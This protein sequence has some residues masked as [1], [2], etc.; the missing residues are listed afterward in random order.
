[1]KTRGDSIATSG[2]YRPE[3]DGLRA[4]A[5]ISVVLYHA[6]L[7]FSGGYVGVDVF[8][9]ISGY[10]ITS[11][12]L[13]EKEASGR[14]DIRAFWERRIRRIFPALAVVVIACLIAGWFLFLPLNYM[15]LGQSVVA[16]SLLASNFYFWSGAEYFAQA[17]DVK[18]LLHTWSLAVEEQF[19]LLFPF[20][21]L[22]LSK[23][24]SRNFLAC[25]ILGL[26]CL[27][28]SLSVYCSYTHRSVNFYLLPTRAWELLIGSLLAVV[29]S[30]ACKTRKLPE[31]M[32]FCG[33]FAILYAA[34]AF[35]NETR[36][37][38]V[39]ALLPC[40]GAA[41]VI[42]SNSQALTIVGRL[43]AVRSI[44]FIGLISYSLY[45]WHWPVLV[46]SQYWGLQPLS[47][48]QRV[49]LLCVSFAMAVVSWRFVEIPFRRRVIVKTLPSVFTV[50][51]VIT[52]MLL[53]TGLVVVQKQGLPSRIS[54]EVLKYAN[55][56]AVETELRHEMSLED[57]ITG[58]FIELGEGN[59]KLPIDIL[60]WGD[61][62]A[63]AV[64]PVLDVL[65]KEHSIRG[66]AATHSS[67]APLVGYESN[68]EYSLG[69]DSVA[70]SNAIVEFIR[71]MKIRKV[72]L[73]ARWRGYDEDG[74]KRGILSTLASLEQTEAKYWIMKPVPEYPWSVPKALA[75]AAQ[76]GR[77]PEAIGLR[78]VD[79]TKA[80]GSLDPIF[81]EAEGLGFG[82]L[83]PIDV[84]YDS[85][86]GHCRVAE[87]GFSLYS[88]THHLTALGAMLLRPMFEP[89]FLKET[90]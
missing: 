39:A 67:T 5:V 24:I 83:D 48:S 89:I 36:F 19:Y 59:K 71:R 1:M 27:S 47:Q 73:V 10:L 76:F 31:L 40:V 86:Q 43:L 74:L 64:L 81:I 56:S 90:E 50:A 42:W 57:A 12:L 8:F 23:R 54:P 7:G 69:E 65:C 35:D 34:F 55:G 44:V 25:G 72:I 28:F 11:L 37:P 41:L 77:N 61:S 70:Y 18:P 68:S 17:S 58:N 60:V 38:G 26:C 66:V 49:L 21:I 13:R 87:D 80:S 84:F 6:K 53:I 62:H 46:F 79:H 3:I 4:V 2:G 85:T 45:L 32:S 30:R 29:P 15:E 22:I 82:I 33:V 16:Q 20:L 78:L 52:A 14:L 88:D 9:V 51:G 63:M 75:A